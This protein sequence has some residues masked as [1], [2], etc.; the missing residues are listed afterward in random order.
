VR[1][2]AAPARRRRREPLG[3]T[4]R[5]AVIP[6][7]GLIDPATQAPLGTERVAR[8]G[9][10]LWAV[11][12]TLITTIAV[13]G[14]AALLHIARYV[15]LIVN[16]DVLLNPA[17][18]WLATWVADAAS[19]AAMCA[20]V[21]TAFV[22][23]E[24]LIARRAAAFGQFSSP[25]PRRGW[26]LRVGCLVP[27]VNWVWAPTYVVELATVEGRY[28]A[29]RPVIW[30]WAL[31]FVLSTLVSA[32]ATATRFPDDTQ[33]I[34]NNTVSFIVA[35]LLAMAATV[36]TA[37]LVFAFERTPVER[38]S[39]RWVVVAEEK[40]SRPEPSEAVEPEGQEPAA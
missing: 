30:V 15:L 16:R 14:M 3:P 33:G 6:R 17:V 21:G 5:Y 36:A 29:V 22:L 32:F 8:R 1:P 37:R 13:L 9:P 24:W 38:P 18:A 23:T 11:R 31:L 25:D 20:I 34:A 28:R 39:H 26:A 10:S 7:W 40:Q 2:G 27:L 35:Y 12:A 4:P 19:V